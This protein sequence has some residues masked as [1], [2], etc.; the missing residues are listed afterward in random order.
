MVTWCVNPYTLV[1]EDLLPMFSPCRTVKK[2]QYRQDDAVRV[3]APGSGASTG[4]KNC[5]AQLHVLHPPSEMSK[6]CD[7]WEMNC[8]YI[9]FSSSGDIPRDGI[10][11][12]NCSA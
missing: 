7:I 8:E 2:P 11:A 1:V 10:V 5:S 9:S 6:S 4:M 12:F 3:D